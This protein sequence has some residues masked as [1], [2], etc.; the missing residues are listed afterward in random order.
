VVALQRRAP[1]KP[2]RTGWTQDR[3]DREK[4]ISEMFRYLKMFELLAAQGVKAALLVGLLAGGMAVSQPGTQPQSNDGA[5]PAG[6]P[7]RYKPNRV[8]KRAGEY[9]GTIW[10]V[11]S[12]RVKSA[13]SGD[14]I[15]FSYRVLDPEKAKILNDK[16]ID[17]FLDAPA[18]QA[19]LVIPSLEKVGQLRQGNTP[20]AGT[21]YWMAFSN[22]RHVVKHGDHVN[23][24]IG[25]FH[26]DGLVVE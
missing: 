13:E 22:P 4:E 20:Q 9:F 19:R 3:G 15:R 16:K 26:A 17:A 6:R 14:L 24:V 2:Q 10:G 5:A 11:D 23:V 12:M 7:V 8:P 25:Q 18:A 1:H 21:S